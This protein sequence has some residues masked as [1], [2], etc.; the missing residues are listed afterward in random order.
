M[1]QG[2]EKVVFVR[3]R[4]EFKVAGF[5][6]WMHC[7]RKTLVSCELADT[8]GP[9]TWH[10]RFRSSIKTSIYQFTLCDHLPADTVRVAGHTLDRSSDQ[11]FDLCPL[12][13]D[14]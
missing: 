2:V 8:T 7:Q 6:N 13:W 12:S 10:Q 5:K 1:Y 3:Q 11:V 9:S 14:D 4:K